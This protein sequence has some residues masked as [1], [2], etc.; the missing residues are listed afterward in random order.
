VGVILVTGTDTGVGKTWVT[1]AL[2]RAL[3]T[4]GRRVVAIKP[5]ESGCDGRSWSEE[6]GVLLAAATGQVLPYAA[7]RRM[8]A[9]VAPAMAAE[10]ERLVIDFDDLLLEIE[11]HSAGSEIVLVEGAG[12]LLAPITWEWGIVDL[13]RALGASA[14]VV[15]SDRLGTINHTLLTLG[16]LELSGIPLLGV[17]LTTPAEPDRSSGANAAA[18]ARMAGHDRVLALPRQVDPFK[19]SASLAKVVRWVTTSP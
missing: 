8:A 5:V 11:S 15:A 17:A 7:L 13:A 18:I 4:A 14:L 2:G 10:A 19:P 1:R 9:P 16:A 3:V 6:D 12:G